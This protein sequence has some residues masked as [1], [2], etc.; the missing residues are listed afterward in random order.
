MLCQKLPLHLKMLNP[1]IISIVN[2]KS[3]MNSWKRRRR[4]RNVFPSSVFPESK[5]KIVLNN[6][7]IKVIGQQKVWEI[8]NAQFMRHKWATNWQALKKPFS[9]WLVIRLWTLLLC[10][11]KHL[12]LA[13]TRDQIEDQM[14]CWFRSLQWYDHWNVKALHRTRRRAFTSERLIY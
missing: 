12:V 9:R 2:Y 5:I 10:P 8:K 1:V 13:I 11:L 7:K 14:V 4:R 3:E 6:Y